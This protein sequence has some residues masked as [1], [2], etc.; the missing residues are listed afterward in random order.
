MKEQI[1][2][3]M[4]EIKKALEESVVNHNALLVRFN[5]AEHL[6]KLADECCGKDVCEGEVI[7]AEQ[8]AC[9]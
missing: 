3:R 1:Q 4:D 9:E 7:C 5:E 8:E 2:A 6:L